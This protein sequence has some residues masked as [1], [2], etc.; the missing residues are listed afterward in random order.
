MADT[1]P[2]V[3]IPQ[4]TPTPEIPGG[5]LAG[6]AP[7]LII[8]VVFYFLVLRPQQKK[9]KDH[10]GMIASLKKGDKVVTGGGIAG[11][12]VKAED[13]WV[14]VEIAQGVVVQVSRATITGLAGESEIMKKKKSG[15]IAN[16]N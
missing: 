12:I 16:D 13:D 3:S 9:F 5:G 14:S 4:T 15:K 7:F 6:F 10:Q 8:L 1:Q 11:T 2:V